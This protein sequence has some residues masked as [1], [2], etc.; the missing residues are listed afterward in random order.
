MQNYTKVG[1]LKTR[2]PE[3]II[4]LAT[5]F[6]DQNHVNMEQENWPVGN[7]YINNW[8]SPTYMVKIE[9]GR[10]RGGGSQLRKQLWDAARES[11]EDWGRGPESNV[12][13]RD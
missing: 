13:L 6:W 3:K 10:L 1:F 12:A 4:E 9:D 5:K 11:I 7:S 2:A 8:V